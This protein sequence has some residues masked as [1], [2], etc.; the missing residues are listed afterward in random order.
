MLQGRA[1]ALCYPFERLFHFTF[2][3]S[4]FRQKKL[5]SKIAA[6]QRHQSEREP[7]FPILVQ[8]L[9][10]VRLALPI[11]IIYKHTH[12]PL[13]GCWV[14]NSTSVCLVSFMC[15]GFLGM[16]LDCIYSF[17]LYTFNN[18]F[19]GLLRLSSTVQ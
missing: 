15:G 6:E 12:G 10:K 3:A 19:F 13:V 4:I 1:A 7:F 8:R 17:Y 5:Y 2:S 18:A 11:F 16:G 14:F 9:K